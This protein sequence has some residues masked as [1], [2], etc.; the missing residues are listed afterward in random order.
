MLPLFILYIQQKLEAIQGY[1]AEFLS[2]QHEMLI[3]T[4]DQ[5]EKDANQK[6]SF[7]EGRL[8]TSLKKQRVSKATQLRT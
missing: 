1:V 8:T 2:Q 4:M 5:M 6:I 7:L 3:E